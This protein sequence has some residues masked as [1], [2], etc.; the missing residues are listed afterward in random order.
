MPRYNNA[1]E[2]E[3]SQRIGNLFKDCFP[4]KNSVCS[5]NGTLPRHGCYDWKI[6]RRK[7]LSFIRAGGASLRM[8]ERLLGPLK[9]APFL[10]LH[11]KSKPVLQQSAADAPL[12]VF[13]ITADAINTA[14]YWDKIWFVSKTEVTAIP[15]FSTPD[16]LTLTWEMWGVFFSP[17]FSYLKQK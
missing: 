9:R 14:L 16:N 1:V 5:K 7:L 13:L 12:S 3:P 10:Y 15:T 17:A 2:S 4:A 11:W 8:P 6:H